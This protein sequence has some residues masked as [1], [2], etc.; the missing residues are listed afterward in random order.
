MPKRTN[1]FQDVVSIIHEHLAGD[2]KIE[3]SAMLR[4]RLTDELREVDVVLRT[5][6][7]PGYETIIGIEAVGRGRA[8]AVDWVESMVAKHQNLPTNQVVLIAEGGFSE[9]ARSLALAERAAARRSG[10]CSWRAGPS[11]PRFLRRWR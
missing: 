11:S 10:A 4:N 1:L 6:N 3:R 9:Q 8:A 2:A 7:G 5:R